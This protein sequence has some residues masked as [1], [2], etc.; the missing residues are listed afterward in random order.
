MGWRLHQDAGEEVSRNIG[1][2]SVNTFRSDYDPSSLNLERRFS[3]LVGLSLNWTSGLRTN[4]DYEHSESVSLSF[5]NNNVREQVSRGIRLSANFSQSGFTLPFLRRF[6]NQIDLGLSF[7]Y[8]EDMTFTYRLNQDLEGVLGEPLDEIDRDPGAHT[9][10]DPE[11]QGDTRINIQP[12]IG[13]QFSQTITVNFEYTYN[14]L[15]PESSNVFPRTDQDFRFN[16]VVNIRS[17]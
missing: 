3:P 14:R 10:P 15:L 6:E 11:R 5:S 7:S 16:V 12:S 13:Y 2:I 4:I 9:P 1:N 17:N 8:F